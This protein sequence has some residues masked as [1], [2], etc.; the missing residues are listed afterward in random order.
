MPASG[1]KLLDQ[2]PHLGK[3]H[4]RELLEILARRRRR[5]Q[6]GFDVSAGIPVRGSAQAVLNQMSGDV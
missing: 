5:S 3:R 4:P 6:P 2:V 1:A